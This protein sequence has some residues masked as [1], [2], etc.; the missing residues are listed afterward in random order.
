MLHILWQDQR[1]LEPSE[2]TLWLEFICNPMLY[3]LWQAKHMLEPSEHNLWQE[4]DVFL[5]V[6]NI[7]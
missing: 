7:A 2:H 1:I 4:L 6:L 5:H 3:I